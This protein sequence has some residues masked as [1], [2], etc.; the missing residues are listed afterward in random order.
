VALRPWTA[1]RAV[2][3]ALARELIEEQ[4]SR[5]VPARV[6]PLG[7]GWD[8]AVFTV[9]DRYVFR[10]PRRQVAVPLIER[11]IAVLPRIAPRLPLPVPVPEFIGAAGERFPWP[12]AGYGMLAGRTADQI[13][14]AD[15]QRAAAAPVL[16]RFLRVLHGLPIDA[17][18]DPVVDRLAAAR[19]RRETGTRLRELELAVPPWFDEPVRAPVARALVHG[20]LHARQIL[21]DDAVCGVIDWGDVHFGDPACDLAIAWMFLPTRARP[22]F[23]TEYGPIDDATWKL[24][25]LRGLHLAAA[26]AV[27]ARHR[28]DE[29]LLREALRAIELTRN[30]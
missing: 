22:A 21:M 2:D 14:P 28:T 27:Y 19:M 4:F 6:E 30:P 15:E 17:G 23:R 7:E 11:E 9:N 12:F 1:E 24:A 3:A 18:P 25:R 8:N 26:L 16:G 13:E 29:R 10:F 5:L 20:D